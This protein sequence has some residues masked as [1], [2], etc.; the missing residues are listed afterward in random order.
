MDWSWSFLSFTALRPAAVTDRL[1]PLG[2]SMDL[3]ITWR[4]TLRPGK[5]N[6]APENPRPQEDLNGFSMEFAI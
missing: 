5:F 6:M 4:R 3:N 2:R 1:K